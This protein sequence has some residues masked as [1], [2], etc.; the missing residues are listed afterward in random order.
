MSAIIRFCLYFFAPFFTAANIVEPA[1]FTAEW[2]TF[3]DSFF[4][5]RSC[6]LMFFN[7]FY[8]VPKQTRKNAF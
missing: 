8:G 6:K 3:H 7:N 4:T 5:T 2:L 1:A